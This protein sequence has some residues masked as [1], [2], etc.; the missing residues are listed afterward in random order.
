[1]PRAEN[2]D[3]LNQRRLR[4]I[5]RWYQK[6]T[7]AQTCRK[8][9][10]QRTMNRSQFSGQRQLTE[11]FITVEFGGGKLPRCRQNA[12]RNGKVE[13]PAFF[14]KIGGGEID[15]DTAR[16][17]FEIRVEQRRAHAILTFLYRRLR[18]AD[19]RKIRQPAGKVHPD[20][21][22]RWLKAN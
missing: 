22:R 19:D 15:G 18:Q 17:K 6:F 8:R 11:K 9:S 13:A 20:G 21:D 2:F 1:M 5:D 14:W 7:F 3:A 4:S 12:K 16:G 10:R